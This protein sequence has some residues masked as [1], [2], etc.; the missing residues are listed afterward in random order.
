MDAAFFFAVRMSAEIEDRALALIDRLRGPAVEAGLEVSWVPRANLHVTMRFLGSTPPQRL[1][2]VRAVGRK[3]AGEVA[4]FLLA[5]GGLGFFPSAQRPSAV[6]A[7]MREIG[8]AAQPGTLGALERLANAL[9]TEL[10][11]CGFAPDERRFV[12]HLTLGRVKGSRRGA[13]TVDSLLGEFGDFELGSCAISEL[14]LF[15]SETRPEGSVYSVVDR[16][17]LAAL[18][19]EAGS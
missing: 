11:A 1:D 17:A 8:P 15:E 7:D 19:K 6:W 18:D 12:A 16:F 5:V 14:V 9:E 4:T 13:R 2:A 3:V 10:R